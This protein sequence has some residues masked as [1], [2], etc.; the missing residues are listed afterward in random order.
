GQFNTMAAIARAEQAGAELVVLVP[1]EDTAEAIVGISDQTRAAIERDLASGYLVV[2]PDVFPAE[3]TLVGWWRVDSERWETLGVISDGRGAAVPEWL[4]IFSAGIGG[5][6]ALL[7]AYCLIDL[8]VTD[9]QPQHSALGCVGMVVGGAGVVA[10]SFGLALFAAVAGVTAGLIR[11]VAF[12][13]AAVVEP[14]VERR[15]A[16][17]ASWFPRTAV[18]NLPAPG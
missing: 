12:L 14:S 4:V 8:A 16:L 2:V 11:L 9:E 13:S 3:E 10:A 7:G 18:A 17:P 6:T 1:G 5:A 15:V